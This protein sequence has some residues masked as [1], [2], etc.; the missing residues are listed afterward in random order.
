MLLAAIAMVGF[1]LASAGPGTA[2]DEPVPTPT[3]PLV[4]TESDADPAIDPD[5]PIGEIIPGPNSGARPERPGDRGG[6]LQLGLFTLLLIFMAVAAWRVAVSG[7]KGR[8]AYAARTRDAASGDGSA[9][10]TDP[11][12][13]T[14][15]DTPADADT[16]VAASGGS[17]PSPR[18]D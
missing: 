3:T 11:T 12:A 17:E 14:D 15:T 2:Q 1:L 16:G 5:S 18:G 9:A 6:S 8:K 10:A 13:E 4:I 7:R